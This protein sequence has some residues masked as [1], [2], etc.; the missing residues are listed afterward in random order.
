MYNVTIEKPALKYILKLDRTTAKRIRNAIAAIAADPK[1]GKLLT[2][3]EAS[4]SYRV[5]DFRVLYD[6]YE[7]QILVIVVKVKGRGDVYN[8]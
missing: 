6:V 4:Y 8:S 5:G 2:K 3:H 7:S 1:I